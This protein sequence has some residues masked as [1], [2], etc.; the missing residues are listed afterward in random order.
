MHA[1]T[2]CYETRALLFIV[3]AA[4]YYALNLLVSGFIAVLLWKQIV[5]K[6]IVFS[7]LS[8]TTQPPSQSLLNFKNKNNKNKNKQNNS[9]LLVACCWLLVVNIID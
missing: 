9:L 3:V 6:N 5:D 8:N 4:R 2:Y 7:L 1:T